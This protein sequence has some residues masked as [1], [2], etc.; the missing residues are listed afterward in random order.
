MHSDKMKAKLSHS[1]RADSHHMIPIIWKM[2]GFHHQFSIV[3]ENATKSMRRTWEIG[4]HSLAV[5]WVLF[6][7]LDSHFMVYNLGNWFPGKTYKPTV[8]GE[9]G[10][11][12]PVV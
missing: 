10:K 9:P 12:V 6:F 3:Q 8:C 7:P 4:T 2:R 11:L 5:V 1:M